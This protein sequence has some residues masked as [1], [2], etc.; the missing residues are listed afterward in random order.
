M[1]QDLDVSIGPGE[2][3]LLAG[4]SGAGKSTLLRAIAG[5]LLTADVGDLT[6]SVTVDGR[7]PQDRP[8]QVG[9]L[10]QDPSAAVV[11]DRVGRDVAFGLENTCVPRSEMP[12]AV[13]RALAAARFPYDEQRLTRA[14]SG[15]ETQRLALA[16]ALALDPRILLLDEPTSML[17]EP[18][19]AEVRRSVLEVCAERGTTLVVVEHHLEPWLDHVDR[20]IVLSREG[21][22]VADGPPREVLDESL[23][24]QGVWVPG[25]PA[26]APLAVDGSLVAPAATPAGDEPLVVARD[27]GV[28]YR[29]VFARRRSTGSRGDTAGAAALVDVSCDLVAG[30]ATVLTGP[31]GAGKSTLLAVLGGLQRPDTG[32]ALASAQFAGRKGRELWRMRS[33]ELARTVAWVPQLPEH[34]LVRHTVL[35]ELLVTSTALGRPDGGRASGASVDDRAHGLLELLGLTHLKNASVHHLSGGEQRRLVVA[36]ALVHGPAGLLLDEPTVGQD[37]LTWAAVVG[38]CHGARGC[39]VAVGLASHD[40]LAAEQLTGSGGASVVRLVEGRVA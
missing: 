10:L 31:S 20:C 37:R 4:P 24:S 38:I 26:P 27:V 9:L 3:V 8:G 33:P 28:T 40:R 16:G 30:H 5:L 12:S 13:R 23:A 11:S 25:L 36:A 19:A 21:V 2:K 18:S 22:V 15:G 17:D 1:L 29:G 32:S 39:G 14:L 7:A 6:G 35:D 34:G